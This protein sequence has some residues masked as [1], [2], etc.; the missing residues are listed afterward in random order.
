MYIA[1][2]VESCKRGAEREGWGG[3]GDDGQR[4]RVRADEDPRAGGIPGCARSLFCV[5]S[6]RAKEEGAAEREA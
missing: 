5:V 6:R 2:F 1:L 4:G 3:N